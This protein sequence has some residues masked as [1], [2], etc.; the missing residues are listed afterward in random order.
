MPLD[1]TRLEDDAPFGN[2][3]LGYEPLEEGRDREN[4]GGDTECSGGKQQEHVLGTVSPE[5][6]Q[7]SEPNHEGSN[8]LQV[9]R[10]VDVRLE[11]HHLTGL[12]YFLDVAHGRLRYAIS[13]LH[14]CGS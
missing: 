6:K 11:P 4:K 12:E 2:G 10:P 3:D 5:P 7:E 14:L 9:N 13:F 1:Q 8:C